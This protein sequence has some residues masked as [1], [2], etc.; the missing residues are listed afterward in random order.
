MKKLTIGL[1]ATAIAMYASSLFLPAFTCSSTKS[2][3]GYEVLSIGY[4][5]LLGLDPRWFGNIGFVILFYG[6]FAKKAKFRPVIALVTGLLAIGS[7]IPALGC[8]GLDT[9][10]LST[11]L[12]VGGVLWVASLLIVSFLHVRLKGPSIVEVPDSQV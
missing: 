9:P 6:C 12:G 8:S 1:V 10:N 3:L 4:M 2:Y 11:T 7:F 5:G